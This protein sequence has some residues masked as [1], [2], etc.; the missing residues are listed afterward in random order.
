LSSLAPHASY[1]IRYPCHNISKGEKI[2]PMQWNQPP[3]MQIDPN[4]NYTAI[5]H[6]EKGDITIELFAKQVPNTVNN[7]VWLSRQKYYDQGIT[8]HRVIPEFMA[9]TGD[10]D[11]RQLGVGGPGYTIKDEPGGLQLKHDPGTVSMAKTAQPH[12]GGS[13]FFIVFPKADRPKETNAHHLDG[14]HTVF[15]RVISGMNVALSLRERNP[16]TDRSPG[17]KIFSIEIVES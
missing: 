16:Q 17:D 10:P 15:G 7:F 5:I 14:V 9:Q 13:Q 6:T 12:T 11:P 1:E 3:A 2:M 8:F 4:K